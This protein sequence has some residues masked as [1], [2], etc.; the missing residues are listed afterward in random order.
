[1]SMLLLWGTVSAQKAGDRISGTIYDDDGPVGLVTVLEVDETNRN[2]NYQMADAQ[3]NFEFQIK[4]PKNRLKFQYI[5]YETLVVPINKTRFNIKLK[6]LNTKETFEVKGERIENGVGLQVP[7]HLNTAAFDKISAEEWEG[8]GAMSVDEALQGRIA[9]LDIVNVSGDL[10]AG[11][12]MRIRGVSS[13]TGSSEPLIVVDGNIFRQ[14]T[15]NFDF[16]NADEQ[17]FSELLNVNPED[18]ESIIVSKDGAATA[19]WGAEGTNGVIEI[20]TKRG[21]AEKTRVSYSYNFKANWITSRYKMLNGDQYTMLM[22]EALFNPALSE[23]ASN[24]IQFNYDPNYSEYQMFNNNTDWIEAVNQ[25]GNNHRH[26]VSLQ[27]GGEKAVFRVSFNYDKTN[28]AII[29]QSLDRITTRLNFDYNISD[30]IKVAS[31][32]SLSYS[33]NN[34]N[35]SQLMGIALKKMPNLAIYREDENG[36]STGEYYHVPQSVTFADQYKS[37]NPLALADEAVKTS[38]SISLSPEFVLRYSLLGLSNRSHQLNYDG[39]IFFNVSNGFGYSFYPSSLSTASWSSD[40][41]NQVSNSSNK[42]RGITTRHSLNFRPYTGE[43]HRL[44]MGGT[45]YFNWNNS[46]NQSNASYGVPNIPSTAIPAT[47]SGMSSGVGESKGMNAVFQVNYSYD[48]KYVFSYSNRLDIT[49]KLGPKHRY[50]FQPSYSLRWNIM[51]EDFMKDVSFIT[52]LSLRSSVSFNGGLPGQDYLYFS[53]Y[54]SASSYNGLSSVAPKNIRL[55]DLRMS[56]IVRYNARLEFSLFENKL[57]GDLNVFKGI[58]ANEIHNN[59]AIATS[60]GYSALNCVNTGK[61]TNQGWEFTGRARNIV[62]TGKFKLDLSMNTGVT[63]NVL[64][65]ADKSVLKGYNKEFDYNN[66]SYL[67]RV[68]TNNSLGSIYGFRSKGVYQ[69]SDYSA[70]EVP[71]VSGPSSPVVKNKDGDVIFQNN[72]VPK[73]MYFAYGTQ[74]E[75]QFRGGD[76]IYEDINHDGNINELDIVYLGNSLPSIIGGFNLRAQINRLTISANFP[77]RIKQMVVNNARMNAEKMHN[78]ENQCQSVSWRWR[79][80]GDKTS[81]PRALYNTGRNWLG[82][83]RF[84]EDASFIRMNNLTLN[85]SIDSKIVKQIGL[86]SMNLS[87]STNNIFVLTKYS[88][89]DPEIGYGSFSIATD[90]T[91]TPK[92]QNINFTVNTT[93]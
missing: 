45:A 85:Y 55:T 59:F 23:S 61:L 28:G 82:S 42:G 69:Y 83:D 71:G 76:A 4:N 15:E 25:I 13:F 57:Y 21:V 12:S 92:N 18:I 50:K 40:Q 33:N 68:Q 5:G 75:Y 86:K 53:R 10:G 7:D 30:R 41:V 87:F 58:T 24:I 80:E 47:I 31:N 11:S 91:N 70:I 48:N 22:K 78:A 93:F 19:I 77:F 79:V 17:R 72:G 74:N 35:Y 62:N 46:S 2:V 16:A 66:G 73:P 9:G 37:A 88:G 34:E 6:Y 67:K 43:K 51:R 84:V 90:N 81:I 64:V 8:V 36:V 32:F 29:R 52:D 20:K 3:G 49:T 63:K 39:N 65:E 26:S 44:L 14:S 38:S 56:D 89:L 60:S 27:G 54:G 1:M